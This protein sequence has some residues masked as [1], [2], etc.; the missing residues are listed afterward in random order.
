[1]VGPGDTQDA[2]SN[3]SPEPELIVYSSLD[4]IKGQPYQE[5]VWR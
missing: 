5:A 2:G 4:I 3:S 1:M